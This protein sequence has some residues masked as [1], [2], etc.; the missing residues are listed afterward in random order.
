MHLKYKETKNVLKITTRKS[1]H[2]GPHLH[3]ALEIVYVTEGTLELGMGTELYHME[4]GDIGFLFPDVI[5]HYQVLCKEKSEACYIQIQP[6]QGGPFYDKLQKFAPECPVVKKEKISSELTNV[7]STVM[8][9]DVSEIAVIEA[10]IQIILARCM[11]ELV[12]VKKESVGSTDL[13]YQIVSY[14][15]AHFKEDMSLEKMSH[16]LG[17]SKFVLSRSFSST[18]HRNFNQYLND[19][20]MNYAI[21]CLENT[22][23]TIL[24]ICME[25]GYESQRTFNRAFKDRYHMSPS[26]YRKKYRLYE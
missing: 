2:V 16:D 22:Q 3:S 6:P 1:K 21:H 8:H 23:D 10:Y 26:E 20:R 4:A 7:I 11:P 19:I 25:C 15:A 9:T 5:H 13:V 17:I 24:D 14:V 18:F 12:L